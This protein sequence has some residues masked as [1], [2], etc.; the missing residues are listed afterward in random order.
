[1]ELLATKN[2]GTLGWDLIR[3]LSMVATEPPGASQL[4]L[5]VLHEI[6]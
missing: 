3:G 6:R 2:L 1:M 5:Y 4:L